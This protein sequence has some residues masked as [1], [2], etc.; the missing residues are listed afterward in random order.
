MWEISVVKKSQNGDTVITT[1]KY[2]KKDQAAKAATQLRLLAVGWT[3]A[4]A[5]TV[6]AQRKNA[7][8]PEWRLH[9]YR[10]T[11]PKEVSN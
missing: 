2:P 8:I 1:S 10:V 7:K 11:P 6:C 4:I 9:Y 3:K 5:D